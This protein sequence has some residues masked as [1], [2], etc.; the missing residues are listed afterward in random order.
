MQTPIIPLKIPQ[1]FEA[2]IERLYLEDG[3]IHID[4]QPDQAT[5]L[6]NGLLEFVDVIREVEPLTQGVEYLN[7]LL[8]GEYVRLNIKA[9]FLLATGKL[10][11]D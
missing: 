7:L 1:S 8:K 11:A 6:C 3:S 2:T 9:M 10:P 5:E 4:P